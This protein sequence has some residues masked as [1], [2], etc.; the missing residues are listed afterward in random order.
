MTTATIG[1]TA[2]PV[3][4]NNKGCE[5]SQPFFNSNFQVFLLLMGF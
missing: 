4:K 1:L 2:V 5:K 3:H